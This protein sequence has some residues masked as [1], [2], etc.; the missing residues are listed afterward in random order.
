MAIMILNIKAPA[1]G[2]HM[3]TLFNI[4]TSYSPTSMNWHFIPKENQIQFGLIHR[5]ST[6]LILRLFDQDGFWGI[7]NSRMNLSIPHPS[8]N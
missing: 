1:C 7:S 3:D 8:L 4:A 6:S 5:I 2:V